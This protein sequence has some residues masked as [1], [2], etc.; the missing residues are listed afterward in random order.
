[1]KKRTLNYKSLRTLATEGIGTESAK[2]AKVGLQMDFYLPTN[3]DKRF[4]IIVEKDSDGYTV[5]NLTELALNKKPEVHYFRF[6]DWASDSVKEEEGAD[7][8]ISRRERLTGE[9]HYF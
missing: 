3:G 6:Y 1:M 8:Y 9:P 5:L 4:G 2:K 7:D